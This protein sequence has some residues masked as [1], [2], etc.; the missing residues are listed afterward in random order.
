MHVWLVLNLS[1][2]EKYLVVPFAEKYKVFEDSHCGRLDMLEHAKSIGYEGRFLGIS[3]APG[4]ATT[5]QC[6]D[7]HVMIMRVPVNGG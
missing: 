3:E 1:K 7:A 4:V 6:G 5:Y 2:A